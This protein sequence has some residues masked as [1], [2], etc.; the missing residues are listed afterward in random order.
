MTCSVPE[1]FTITVHEE[2]LTDV[3]IVAPGAIDHV[4]DDDLELVAGGGAGTTRA[5]HV[6]P[7]REGLQFLKEP[8]NG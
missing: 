1:A 2:S 8:T 4:P 3:H 5:V 6:H 7:S